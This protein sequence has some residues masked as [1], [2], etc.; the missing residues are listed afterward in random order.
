MLSPFFPPPLSL[1][2]ALVRGSVS[3]EHGLGL[4]KVEYIGM[5]KSAEMIQLMQN[6]KKI[7][8]PLAILNPYKV[9]PEAQEKV[10]I[11]KV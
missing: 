5:S 8:D 3:A 6:I 11:K 1:S 10:T 9:L 4:S 7:F 2:L